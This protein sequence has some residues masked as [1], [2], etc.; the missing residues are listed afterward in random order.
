MAHNPLA[1]INC[2]AMAGIIVS[3][4]AEV[5]ARRDTSITAHD[6]HVLTL[7]TNAYYS[8]MDAWGKMEDCTPLEYV[9]EW[10]DEFNMLGVFSRMKVKREL[11]HS[12]GRMGSSLVELFAYGRPGTTVGERVDFRH[13]Y[14]EAVLV[15][16]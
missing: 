4:S 8:Y 13:A 11:S 2:R 1:T 15:S 3:L 16:V 6:R 5:A 9:I 7:L 10:D 14:Q 12:T